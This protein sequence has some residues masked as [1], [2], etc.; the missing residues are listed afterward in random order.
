MDLFGPAH[1]DQRLLFKWL[2]RRSQ[3]RSYTWAGFNGLI[4]HLGVKRPGITE[5]AGPVQ[6]ALL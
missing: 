2:N 1:F 4:K 3:R 5:R 6:L